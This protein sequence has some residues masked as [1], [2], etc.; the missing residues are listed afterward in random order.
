[1]QLEVDCLN[2]V[3]SESDI[4]AARWVGSNMRMKQR[5]PE[6]IWDSCAVLKLSGRLP[7]VILNMFI[8]RAGAFREEILNIVSKQNRSCVRN[9]HIQ[10]NPMNSSSK[11]HV[12][13]KNP[14]ILT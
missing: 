1:M 3:R 5:E 2:I 4:P 11:K 13:H 8:L 12:K 7:E 9:I 14:H 6:P 10:N